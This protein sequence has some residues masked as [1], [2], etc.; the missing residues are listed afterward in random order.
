MLIIL[1]LLVILRLPLQHGRDLLLMF[2]LHET[3]S[4]FQVLFVHDSELLGEGLIPLLVALGLHGLA[5]VVA[6]AA[7]LGCVRFLQLPLV[8]LQKAGDDIAD[9]G[10]QLRAKNAVLQVE[11]S[12][13]LIHLLDCGKLGLRL[14]VDVLGVGQVRIL[15]HFQDLLGDEVLAHLNLH[16]IPEDSKELANESNLWIVLDDGLVLG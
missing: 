13:E 15:L 16:D 10:V 3:H 7:V 9:E 4:E 2:V 11:G 5:F 6:V 12:D 8:L 14:L 1:L